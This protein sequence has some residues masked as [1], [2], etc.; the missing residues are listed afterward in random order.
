MQYLEQKN[1]K[2]LQKSY[3]IEE[4]TKSEFMLYKHHQRFGGGGLPTSIERKKDK[5]NRH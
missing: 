3:T 4:I 5:H 1:L 2:K